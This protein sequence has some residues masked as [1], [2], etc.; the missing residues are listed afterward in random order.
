MNLSVPSAIDAQ[1]IPPLPVMFHGSSSLPCLIELYQP[2]VSR[3]FPST[4]ATIPHV[5]ICYFV[6]NLRK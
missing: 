3:S 5:G 4:L 2:P 1:V 6:L